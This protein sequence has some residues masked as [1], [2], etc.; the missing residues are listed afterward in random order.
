MAARLGPWSITALLPTLVLLFAFQCEAALCQPLVIALLAVPN[1]IQVNFGARLAYPLNRKLGVAHRVAEPST[2]IASNYLTLAVATAIS[3]AGLQR[4][5]YLRRLHFFKGVRG[6]G[7]M[8]MAKH[9]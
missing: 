3:L 9:G 4:G 8:L 1:L 6:V 2:H 5:R 7:G